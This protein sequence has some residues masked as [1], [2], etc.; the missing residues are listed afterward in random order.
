M[1]QFK[2]IL[3]MPDTHVPYEDSKAVSL[4][5]NVAKEMN[6]D[7]FVCLGDFADFYSVSFFSKR[8]DRVHQLDEE[9][10]AINVHLDYMDEIMPRARKIFIAG[11]HEVR[12]ERYLT[13]KAPAL[14]NMVK[15]DKLF[16]LD[17]RKNWEYVP[18]KEH[19]KIGS[20]YLTHDVGSHGGN[21]HRKSRDVFNKSTIIGHCLPWTYKVMTPSGPVAFSDLKIGDEVLSYKD[22]NVVKTLVQEK[23]HYNYTGDLAC[24]DNN[25]INMKMTSEHH[26]YTKD[27]KYIKVKDALNEVTKADL[28][29]SALPYDRPE[30]EISDTML[31]LI[32]AVSADGSYDG[33]E[34]N[35]PQIRFHFRKER[36]VERL[37]SLVN[38][39]GY[40]IQWSKSKTG[41]MKSKAISTELRLKLKEFMPEKTL[42][43]FLLNLSA[44]QRQIVID[45][46]C[47]W[48]GSI[49]IADGIDYGSRQFCSHKREE[50]ELIQTLLT[51]HGIRSNLLARGNVLT[52]NVEKD[53]YY[54]STRKL[55]DFVDWEEVK[56]IE[57]GCITTEHQNFFV[58]T[59]EGRVELSGNTHRLSYEIENSALGVPHL[60]AMFGWLGDFDKID[61][62]H[63]VNARTKWS[64]GFGYGLI[65]EK[66]GVFHI[67]PTPIIE[68]KGVYSCMINGKVY[69][70]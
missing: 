24:F 55:A 17:K 31:R 28:V 27:G 56:D 30:F 20:L 14:F 41:T 8:P 42:P 69:T 16:Q 21:A 13:D 15:I 22:G 26:I 62:M 63:R 67:T 12:L 36:K 18:Y 65:D 58:V 3:I 23:V 25:A 11:N 35:I 54:D 7:I 37:T 33:Y 51:L 53:R 50:I 9:L 57:V 34:G 38:E 45:E 6:P 48:D 66:T 29:T 49:I 70:V 60:A 2:K 61:Y 52:Y 32:V 68:R 1:K 64:H 4:F 39:A 5:Y 44:R 46:L 19:I 59:D 43:K 47:L 10:S 40:D